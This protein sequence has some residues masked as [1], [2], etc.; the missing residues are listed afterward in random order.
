MHER[1]AQHVGMHVVESIELIHGSAELQSTS[2]TKS[3]RWAMCVRRV[4]HRAP[5][6]TAPCGASR[7]AAAAAEVGVVA[8]IAAVTT[9]VRQPQPMTTAIVD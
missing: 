1:H 2:S 7:N 4:Q 3:M 5:S 9:V 6:L 8:V